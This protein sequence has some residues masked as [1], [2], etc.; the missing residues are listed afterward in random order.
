MSGIKERRVRIAILAVVGVLGLP[1][2]S[3]STNGAPLAASGGLLASS[4]KAILAANP[5]CPKGQ[6]WVPAGYAKHGKYRAG[7]CAPK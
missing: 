6:R 3:Q 2:G 5:S 4:S 1:V 7:H